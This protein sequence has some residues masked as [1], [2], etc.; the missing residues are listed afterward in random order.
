MANL[1]MSDGEGEGDVK[2]RRSPVTGEIV[3]HVRMCPVLRKRI[4]FIRIPASKHELGTPRLNLRL[5]ARLIDKPWAGDTVKHL[6]Y[7]KIC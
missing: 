1:G 7:S 4:K 3:R 6:R 5:L 2:N